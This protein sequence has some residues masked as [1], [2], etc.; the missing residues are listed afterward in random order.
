MD[1]E[2]PSEGGTA[3]ECFSMAV[4]DPATLFGIKEGETAPKQRYKLSLA[5]IHKDPDSYILI[6]S[7]KR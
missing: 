7:E 6:K 4:S 1:F 5:R 3:K 2:R